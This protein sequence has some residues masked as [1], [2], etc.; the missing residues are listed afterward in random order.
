LADSGLCIARDRW[1]W[2]GGAHI[3]EVPAELDVIVVRQSSNTS[4]RTRRYFDNL[5]NCG[6]S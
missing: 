1:G 2:S 4:E 6:F 3:Y 5:Q